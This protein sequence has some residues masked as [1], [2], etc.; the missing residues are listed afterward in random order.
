[1]T[2]RLKRS[3]LFLLIIV[4][5][6]TFA[7]LSYIAS[8]RS[9][10]ERI[11]YMD[12]S[13]EMLLSTENSKD[14]ANFYSNLDT[15]KRL[16][17][18]IRLTYIAIDGKVLYD[19]DFNPRELE[20]HSDRK[21]FI[22]TVD[23]TEGSSF[24][25]SATLGSTVYYLSRKGENVLRISS[26]FSIFRNLI[27]TNILIVF[28]IGILALILLK[29][30]TGKTVDKIIAPVKTMSSSPKK[31]SQ[32]IIDSSYDEI[33]P[34][35]IEIKNMTEMLESENMKL[36]NRN[37]KIQ[38]ITENVKEGMLVIDS[39]YNINLINLPM[40]KIFGKDSSAKTLFDLTD[41][42]N[43]IINVKETFLLNEEMSFDLKV[44]NMDYK[45]YMD[46]VDF[47]EESGLFVLFVDNT[48]NKRGED[49]RREFTANVSHELKSPLTSINGYAELISSGLANEKDI[50]EFARIINKE[51]LRLLDTI[52]DLLKLSKLDEENQNIEVKEVNIKE[53]FN[54][55]YD[56][57]VPR[58][59]ERNIK[60]SFDID[61][62]SISTNES[63]F[64]DLMTNIFENAIKYNKENGKI[65]VKA[66]QEGKNVVVRIKDTGIGIKEENIDRIFERFYIVDKART[67]S[68]K[69]TGLGLSIVKHIARNLG[70]TIDVKSVFNE[71]TEFIITI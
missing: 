60:V 47:N 3:I 33:K 22:E 61:D 58:L 67:S 41:N 19:S 27:F 17:P 8:K 10:D 9:I 53:I 62:L 26:E 15:F 30:F 66:K 42:E 23:N 34:Y 2:Y 45:V 40:L 48:E 59:S 46:P 49:L 64:I 69:S 71:M 1:M 57:F 21:E 56:K 31:I 16:N 14:N 68:M 18:D 5:L 37:E 51:G 55:I 38:E 20:N 39:S 63:L 36:K 54:S 28:V 4:L 24:R 13:L 50:K 43:F 65:F 52:D 29:F 7:A 32:K 70:Y 35:L 12:R 25:K 44:G 6:I 11:Q